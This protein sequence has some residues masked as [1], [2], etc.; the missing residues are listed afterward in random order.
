V[1]GRSSSITWG[2]W[3]PD[4][5]ALG[6][7]RRSKVGGDH[8]PMPT[9]FTST[10]SSRLAEIL[11]VRGERRAPSP[12]RRR[13]A[14][15]AHRG[16]PDCRHER[17]Q[18]LGGIRRHFCPDRAAYLEHEQA[19]TELKGLMPQDAKEAIGHGVRAKRSKS[20]AV[21]FD[22]FVHEGS[23][24]AVELIHRLPR[25]CIGQGAGGVDQPGEITGGNHPA[26][27]PWR[28]RALLPLHCAQ[29]L[30]PARGG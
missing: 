21:S 25:G 12:I 20:A 18:R 13:A 19:K 7:H 5:G 10:L 3:L 9:H 15:T 23:H 14:K 28:A 30:R 2:S 11:A 16:G 26:T 6:D 17:I 29:G 27:W 4:P 8:Q 24:A 1:Y 22:L